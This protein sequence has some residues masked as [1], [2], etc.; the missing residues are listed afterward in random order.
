[1][2]LFRVFFLADFAVAKSYVEDLHASLPHTRERAY[3]ALKSQAE[4]E[5]WDY[6]DFSAEVADLEAQFDFNVPRI[7]RF[8]FLIYLHSIVEHGLSELARDVRKRRV[9]ALK[10]NEVTGS[11]I[12]RTQTYLTKVAGF[13]LSSLTRWDVLRDLAKV[14]DVLVHR[15]GRLG[16]DPRERE[17]L[18]QLATRRQGLLKASRGW[19]RE[20]SEL[21]ISQPLCE[22]FA[23]EAHTFFQE[24]L[25]IV[26]PETHPK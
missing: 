5:G 6:A 23:A 11:A 15:G 21:Q 14:R 10:H 8:S 25:E 9:L 22:L 12:E 3:A 1:M 4:A 13:D 19:D 17:Q 2:D 26:R 20:D 7:L 16:S 18:R 24:L